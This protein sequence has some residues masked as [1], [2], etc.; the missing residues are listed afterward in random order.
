LD[1]TSAESVAAEPEISR[2]VLPA[3]TVLEDEAAYDMSDGETP[4]T[5][6]VEAL[7]A[8]PPDDSDLIVVLD[9]EAHVAQL[10]RTP[11]KAHRQ[12]Y[13]RLFTKLREN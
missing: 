2:E 9:A 3:A 5:L 1:V 6:Q 13:R 4:L 8:V 7:R 11:G 10:S 12:D